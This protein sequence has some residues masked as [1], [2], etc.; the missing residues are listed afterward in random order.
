ML[1]GFLHVVPGCLLPVAE[2]GSAHQ[3]IPQELLHSLVSMCCQWKC[4]WQSF[5]HFH[6]QAFEMQ[7]D[8]SF[9]HSYGQFQSQL[10]G[11]KLVLVVLEDVLWRLCEK[12]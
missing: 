11:V 3:L 4:C 10:L 2:A 7:R 12:P 9:H 5:Y 6:F 8:S 1:W